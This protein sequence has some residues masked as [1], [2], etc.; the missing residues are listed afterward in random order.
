MKRILLPLIVAF[1]LL[2]IKSNAQVGM[3]TATPTSTLDVAAKNAT[4]SASNVDG[5]LVPR[6]DRLRAQSMTSIPTSTLVYV[7]NI[8]TGGQAG[9][10][11]NVDAVGYYYYDGTAWVKLHNPS[12]ATFSSV[13]IYNTDGS[14]TG[15][16]LVTQGTNTLAFSSNA[17]NG[18]SVDGT[19]F[20]IDA[21]NNRVGIGTA[22]PN[23]QLELGQ[24]TANRKLVL[25]GSVNNDNQFYGLG[26][27]PG[28]L[29]YQADAL[30]TDHVFYAGTGATTSNELMRIKGLGSVGIG[31]STPQKLLHV[32]GSLQVT[33]EFNVGGNATTAGSAG[34]IGQILT[35]G[36]AGTAPSWQTAT[37]SVN[38]YNADGSLT[39]NRL[40]T[41]GTNTLAFSSNAVNGFSVDG[42]TFSIDALNNTVG[43]GTIAP[44]APLQ[45]ASNTASRKIVMYESANNDHQF[46]G[47]GINPSA[48]RYQ[49]GDTNSDHIFF[50]GTSATASNELMRIKGSGNVGVGTSTPQ[51]TLHVNGTLQVTNELN[52]GGNATTAG[53]AGTI[54][55]ILTSGGAGVAP[56]WQTAAPSVNIYN[57]DGSLTGNRL[58]TQ[59]T[60]TLA[61]SSNAVNGFSVDGSTFSVDALNNR[62]GVG[63]AT[64]HGQLQ[65]GNAVVNRKIVMFETADNDN[66]FYGFG[67]N[68]GVM[69][70]QADRTTTDHVFYAGVT[71]GASSNELMRIKGTGNV[72]I[73]TSTPAA[74]LDIAGTLKVADGTEGINK[75]LISDAA[76]LASWKA[77][78]ESVY[79]QGANSFGLL[80]NANF[81]TTNPVPV[82][83]G[84][85]VFDAPTVNVGNAYN[86]TTGVFTTPTT[87]IY[88]VNAGMNHV[89]EKNTANS[90]FAVTYLY[91]QIKVTDA[92]N[93][94]I[95]IKGS[96]VPVLNGQIVLV[97]L[98]YAAASVQT[99]LPLK[100]GDKVEVVYNTYSS[101]ATIVS[102]H[103]VRMSGLLINRVQ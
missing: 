77:A 55:Q 35:S 22:S 48:Q 100:T 42:S 8:A 51:K 5:L 82:N 85:Y 54:G 59:G 33:N 53:S 71:G 3:N 10:T 74:K 101:G 40:V 50:A 95:I 60:N 6:I 37:P 103:P 49:V 28:I 17:V 94:S 2:S 92:S 15:N 47:F 12:N 36:G 24:T 99:T 88:S 62:V 14:L 57:A 81:S 72:G 38:I 75:L 9:I 80:V 13:N 63:T 27:N 58:V 29:R 93:N 98:Q 34:T 78:G 61:F 56:V 64:P 18:F 11:A 7:N 23:G 20:S 102:V 4:G 96:V 89:F 26:V 30:G 44:N 16:R 83:G 52:V 32:A 86:T 39:G 70:Y 90:D 19:T 25:Y 45:F 31:T 65:L 87:G 69:R 79:T 68:S 76:G 97:G 84:N 1:S 91:P 46:F 67:V 21:L 66:E 41:Q 43:I 73:G